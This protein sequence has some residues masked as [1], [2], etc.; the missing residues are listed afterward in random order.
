MSIVNC[1]LSIKFQLVV[2]LLETGKSIISYLISHI[3]YL[4]FISHCLLPLNGPLKFH[5]LSGKGV[6]VF[7]FLWYNALKYTMMERNAYD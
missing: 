4:T 2:P 1:Q 6:E 7:C 3:S 5:E